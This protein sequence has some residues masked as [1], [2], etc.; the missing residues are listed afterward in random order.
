MSTVGARIRNGRITQLV[1][2]SPGERSKSAAEPSPANTS[3]WM[4]WSIGF[5]AFMLCAVAFVLWGLNGA[6]ILFDMIVTLCL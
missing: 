6:S 2:N 1:Q 4:L 5:V 3:S